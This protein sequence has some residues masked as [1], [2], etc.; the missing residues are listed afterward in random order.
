[1]LSWLEEREQFNEWELQ[2]ALGLT[3]RERISLLKRMQEAGVITQELT[4]VKSLFRP[5]YRVQFKVNKEKLAEE[6]SKF[7]EILAAELP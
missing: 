7:R 2:K 6:L 5:L 3:S 1:M 4:E